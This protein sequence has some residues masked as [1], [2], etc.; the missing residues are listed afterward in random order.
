MV[1]ALQLI[2][3]PVELSTVS[4]RVSRNRPV[5]DKTAQNDPVRTDLR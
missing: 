5:V 2:Q 3:Y 1:K 4:I